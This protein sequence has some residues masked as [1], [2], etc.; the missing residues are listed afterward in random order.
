MRNPNRRCNNPRH[1]PEGDMFS[2]ND[3]ERHGPVVAGHGQ[4][5]V[6]AENLRSQIPP[7]PHPFFPWEAS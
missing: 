3:G 2:P 1:V 4:T 7:F 5:E 6:A